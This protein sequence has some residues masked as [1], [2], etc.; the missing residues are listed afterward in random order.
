MTIVIATACAIAQRPWRL[1][2][3]WLLL[4]IAVVGSASILGFAG[5]EGFL[6][7]ALRLIL[8]GRTLSLGLLS[9]LLESLGFA[10]T[11]RAAIVIASTIIV[12][13]AIIA[14]TLGTHIIVSRGLLGL[15][16]GRFIT[17]LGP[18]RLITT[19][20][21]CRLLAAFLL[22]F[23]FLLVKAVDGVL[24]EQVAKG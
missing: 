8:A 19:L 23:L 11:G 9:F 3:I 15:G 5:P 24:V 17:T 14:A 1:F 22:L 13:T 6:L 7:H 16:A 10:L 21:A 18:C 4:A 12:T 2:L 20:G